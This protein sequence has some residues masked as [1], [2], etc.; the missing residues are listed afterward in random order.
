MFQF[1]S[2][3]PRV[4]GGPEHTRS[5]GDAGDH[6]IRR[7]RGRRGVLLEVRVGDNA[8]PIVIQGL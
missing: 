5:Q 2:S 8:I 1:N 4:R 6:H 3:L 7:H